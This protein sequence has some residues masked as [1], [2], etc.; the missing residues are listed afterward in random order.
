[1]SRKQH[2][3]RETKFVFVLLYWVFASE[4]RLIKKSSFLIAAMLL[5]MNDN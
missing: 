1:M 5:T 4:A 2:E 3:L